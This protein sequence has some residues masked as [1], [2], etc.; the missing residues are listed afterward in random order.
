MFESICI[1]FLLRKSLLVTLIAESLEIKMSIANLFIVGPPGPIF[2]RQGRYSGSHIVQRVAAA[3]FY[4]SLGALASR[5]GPEK[6]CNHPK[7]IQ[8]HED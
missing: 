8:L 4:S 6:P 5:G 7:I 2:C 1:I 3:A